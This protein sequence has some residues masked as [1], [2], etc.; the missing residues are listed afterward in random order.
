[1]LILNPDRVRFQGQ[2]WPEVRAV[3][4]DRA[5][6]KL[7]E[8]R[9]DLGPYL[10]FSD[11][12][13]AR[14]TIRVSQTLGTSDMLAPLPGDAGVLE[15]WT[16]P[17]ASQAQRVRIQCDAVVTDVRHEVGSGNGR[18]ASRTISLLAISIDGKVDPLSTIA[19]S[20]GPD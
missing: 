19:A 9:G 4:V 12:A 10:I 8:E 15:W 18:G 14:V 7:I 20:T 6:E 3:A 1:M 2:T 16:S 5:A 13:E 17:N 11:V